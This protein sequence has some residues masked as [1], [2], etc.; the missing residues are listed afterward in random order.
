M[1]CEYN[2]AFFLD[3][4]AGSRRSAQEILPVLFRFL[5]PESVVDVGCGV[6]GWL[7]EFQAAGVH[8]ILGIDGEHVDR[9]LL[10]IDRT[11]FRATD[12][13][14]DFV[15]LIDRRF[16]L[17]ISLEVAEHIETQNAERF[18]SSLCR[19]SDVVLFSAALPYQGGSSHVNENWLEYWAL[20][21]RGN[22]YEPI[23]C[24]RP[25]IWHN[26]D[27]VWW[28][29][30]NILLFTKHEKRLRLFPNG[31]PI[32][33]LPPSYVHPEMLL[34]WV[35]LHEGGFK[36]D[37][38]ANYYRDLVRAYNSGEKQWPSQNEFVYRN[39]HNVSFSLRRRALRRIANSLGNLAR[40]RSVLRRLRNMFR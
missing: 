31:A 22:G 37:R 18:I 19:L 15:P 20:L 25:L 12:L 28:Y 30:Q 16:D 8:D 21:F 27:I 38:D 17:A 6:G 11:K 29:R 32:A 3:Q 35:A 14:G 7:A 34:L 33:P 40:K 26:S 9:D 5:R 2:R 39:T 13:S 1:V 10:L 24:L 36:L 23:D 4:A